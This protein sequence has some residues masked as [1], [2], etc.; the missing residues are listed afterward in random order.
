MEKRLTVKQQ[1]E[2]K[3]RA[4]AMF[5]NAGI[6]LTEN[7]K[8]NKL[9]IVDFGLGYEGFFKI[10]IVMVTTINTDK[11]CGRYI[12]FFPGQSCL[13]HWHPDVDGNSGKEETF[14]TLWGNVYAYSEGE[15][16]QDIKAKV[17][18]GFEKYY[19]CAHESVLNPGEQITL[20]LHEKHWF[21]GGP[22]G[23][24]A[25]E[26]STCARDAYDQ[27]EANYSAEIH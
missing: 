24:I 26:T 11:Y 14:R 25:F 23:G 12:L 9:K 20:R 15:K 1:E 13:Q 2:I 7:E 4:E 10:G 5:E 21:Q 19:T 18:E 6:S 17:P 8:M 16:T 3:R 27:N 22:D